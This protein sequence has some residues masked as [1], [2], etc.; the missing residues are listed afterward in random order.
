MPLSPSSTWTMTA[1]WALTTLAFCLSS[2]TM[3]ATL[4]VGPGMP[5]RLPSAAA[6]AAHDG[7]H[8]KIAAGS[9]SDCAVWKTNNLT[10]EGAGPDATVISGRPCQGKALFIAQGRAI[11]VRNLA[12]TGAHV[13]DFNGAGIRAEGGDLTV[14]H[15]RF[16]EDE[17]G[18][19][20]GALPGVKIIVR[21][22][23]FIADGTCEGGGGCAHGIYA[24]HIALLR[25]EHS[26]FLRTR[27]GHHIKSRALRTEV[28][29][30]DLEDGANGTSSLAVDVPNGGAVVLRDNHI[31]KGP[32]SENHMAAVMIGEEGAT[33]PTP[34]IIVEHNTF[35]VDGSYESFLL[36]NRT[37]TVAVL[38]GNTSQGNAQA[39]LGPGR[40]K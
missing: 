6:A 1:A 29:G 15:V 9:Y 20:S 21:D 34:D 27:S 38:T 40:V 12:L 23:E 39:L 7:D 36:G 4:Q 25:V 32:R 26:R 5:Y 35:R 16:A 14:E 13:A 8:I 18:I 19:M 24:G 3:A 37:P 33:Q 2:P 10:I 30:C 28:I 31:E 17:N 11:T 22:S